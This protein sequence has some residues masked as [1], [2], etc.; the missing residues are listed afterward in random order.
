MIIQPRKPPAPKP[1]VVQAALDLM[2]QLGGQNKEAMGYLQDLR[3]AIVHN[4]ELLDNISKSRQ[5][6]SQLQQR[7]TAVVKAEA[8]HKANTA[9]WEALKKSMLEA[10][11]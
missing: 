2:T 11:K 8:T 3:A 10:T 9:E 4:T 7:E 5:I 1:E 6:L